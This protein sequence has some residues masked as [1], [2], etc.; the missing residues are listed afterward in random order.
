M[1]RFVRETSFSE[2]K[3][4]CFRTNSGVSVFESTFHFR[5][6]CDAFWNE[7]GGGNGSNLLRVQLICWDDADAVTLVL[8]HD[9]EDELTLV[10]PWNGVDAYERV[11]W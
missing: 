3:F 7:S 9:G 8:R 11:S 4:T 10:D 5:K 1:V 6:S 2:I